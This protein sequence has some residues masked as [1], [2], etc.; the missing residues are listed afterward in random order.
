[1]KWT[2][3]EKTA[4]F[5][6][7]EL[8]V[9]IAIMGIL[10]GIGTA[11]YGGYVKY[12]NKGA[13]KQLVGDIMRAVET[14]VYAYDYDVPLQ[15]AGD[16][17]KLPVGFVVLTKDDGTQ[18]VESSSAKKAASVDCALADHA[19]NK[20][21]YY[22]T[23]A[24]F[25]S[26]YHKNV[27]YKTEVN[28]II[29]KKTTTYNMDVYDA[30]RAMFLAK[31]TEQYC[32][33]HSDVEQI[34]CYLLKNGQTY[35]ANEGKQSSASNVTNK[36]EEVTIVFVNDSTFLGANE[37]HKA[38][39]SYDKV[40]VEVTKYGDSG[41][42][43]TNNGVLLQAI[44]AAFVDT[45][46]LT[47]K[48][49]EWQS[50]SLSS[51]L[52]T[53]Y[54]SGVDDIVEAVKEIQND[55]GISDADIAE[56]ANAV[57]EK[58]ED[59]LVSQWTAI[60]NSTESRASSSSF[61]DYAGNYR[62]YS[63]RMM[64]NKAFAT[65]MLQNTVAGTHTHNA[66]TCS[67]NIF[68]Y[69]KNLIP[70]SVSIWALENGDSWPV[71][72]ECPDCASIYKEYIKGGENSPSVAN[73]KAIY[74]TMS[75]IAASSGESMASE[76]GLLGNQT[77]KNYVDEVT[78]MYKNINDITSDNDSCIVIEVSLNENG[79]VVCDVFP[80]EANPRTEE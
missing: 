10:A 66:T 63:M 70:Q 35:V 48:S 38:G 1:M 49:D 69:K 21:Y 8:I 43:L 64:Y 22:G 62:Y 42:G 33:E 6:L 39:A 59:F 29:T 72:I 31:P 61:G 17:I 15:I 23:K 54:T 37:G 65:Y 18:L 80:A 75:T 57:A 47:L 30:P 25:E 51:D 19:D 27:T 12:A 26:R 58:G 16:G 36:Y 78:K 60:D 7:V 14:G 45:D 3:F 50:G 24:D 73:A 44:K 71:Y 74:A 76:G 56:V 41:A 34:K 2:K 13:D 46:A 55:Y 4:G 9:V 20:L 53:V 40:G 28:L 79:E 5:T 68:N 77:Y 52:P 11:G 67:N 32:T